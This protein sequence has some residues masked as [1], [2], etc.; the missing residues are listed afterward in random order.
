MAEQIKRVKYKPGTT[1]EQRFKQTAKLLKELIEDGLRDELVRRKAVEIVNQAGIRGHDEIG[2]I[3]AICKWVQHNLNY[4]KDPIY[5]EYFH[6]ARRLIKDAENGRSAAD[7]DDFVI[8]AASLLGSLGY[9]TGAII[10]DS[11][12]DGLLNHVMVVTRTFAPTP[13][14]GSQWIP[15]ELIFTDFELGESVNISQVY[16]L[17]ADKNT[18]RIP[19]FDSNIAGYGSAPPIRSMGG[20]QMPPLSL[21]AI[22]KSHPLSGFIGRL[23]R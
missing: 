1:I 4:R 7:C 5:V 2:E 20:G 22:V 18:T 15:C 3:R 21:G 19:I 9:E 10:V 6:S 23:I 8:V 17:I 13:Q 11:N 16:P 14:F 12:G